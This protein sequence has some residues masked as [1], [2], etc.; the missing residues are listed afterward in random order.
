MR[1][2]TEAPARATTCVV[3]VCRGCCCG[4]SAKH[5]DVDH[6]R[7]L[8]VLQGAAG[9]RVRVAQC[10][11]HCELSNMVVVNPSPAGRA[12]GGRPT[13]LGEVLTDDA[14]DRVVRWVEAGGPGIVPLPPELAACAEAV[15]DLVSRTTG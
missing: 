2:L 5:P 13:W 15:R 7:H 12:A 11:A 3:S 8:A 1:P 10:L 6:D 14:V 4:T 9:G